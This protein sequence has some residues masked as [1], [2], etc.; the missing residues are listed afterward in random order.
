[1]IAIKEEAEQNRRKSES[2]GAQAHYQK[3]MN[4]IAVEI[5]RLLGNPTVRRLS[6]R[7]KCNARPQGSWCIDRAQH[8]YEYCGVLG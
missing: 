8:Y 6:P 4:D 1:M 2:S 7:W 3:K 5:D